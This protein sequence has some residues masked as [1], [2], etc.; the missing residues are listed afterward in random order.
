M[1]HHPMVQMGAGWFECRDGGIVEL[2]ESGVS[3]EC[4]KRGIVGAWGVGVSR[5]LEIPAKERCEV[6]VFGE[7]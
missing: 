4:M 5:G 1:A 6:R 2:C 7:N 3:S